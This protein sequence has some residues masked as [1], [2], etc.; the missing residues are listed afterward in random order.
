MWRA[1][2]CPR[3]GTPSRRACASTCGS[4]RGSWCT[5]WWESRWV[6][7]FPVS[8]R[9]RASWRSH[10]AAT[11]S[12]S[13]GV[14]ANSRCSPRLKPGCRS[15]SAAASGLAGRSTSRLALGGRRERLAVLLRFRPGR[16]NLADTEEPLAN[17]IDL[18]VAPV[19]RV[20]ALCEDGRRLV[21]GPRLGEQLGLVPDDA[22]T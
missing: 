16:E 15:A 5:S 12:R 9:N 2:E 14:G 22:H 7:V 3:T 10:S 4:T 1:L 18:Q 19:G 13:P 11:P 21:R 20:I 8:S 6:G 17:H